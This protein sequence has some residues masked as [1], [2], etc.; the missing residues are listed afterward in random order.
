MSTTRVGYQRAVVASTAAGG[1]AD[2]RTRVER[3]ASSS[4][5]TNA[6]PYKRQRV[7][8]PPS[9]IIQ[10]TVCGADN[11]PIKKHQAKEDCWYAYC[12]GCDWF[13]CKSFD[14]EPT[15]DEPLEPPA[16]KIV[17]GTPMEDRFQDQFNMLLTRI[18]SL[19][20]T[21]AAMQQGYQ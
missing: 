1:V 14:H 7:D 2:T 20:Q 10:C 21:I 3:G 18:E 6:P 9:R 8:H 15:A 5:K 13:A 4:A 12:T 11:I 17:K 19:E 16:A